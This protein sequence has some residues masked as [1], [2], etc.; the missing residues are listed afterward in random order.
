MGLSLYPCWRHYRCVL[1]RVAHNIPVFAFVF[2][3]WCLFVAV[4]VVWLVRAGLLVV[5]CFLPR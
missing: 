4:A 3:P 5:L 2:I 1:R